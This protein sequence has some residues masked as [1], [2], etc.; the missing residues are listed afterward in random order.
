MEE[1]KRILELV[2][3]GILSTEEA[4]SLLENLAYQEDAQREEKDFGKKY[5]KVDADYESK[6]ES[7]DDHDKKE[8][9]DEDQKDSA[10]YLDELSQQINQYSAKIDTVNEE[11][12][13]LQNSLNNAQAKI[14]QSKEQ[15]NE[16]YRDKKDEIR[17][18]INNA[19]R[20]KELLSLVTE[21]DQS[22][23]ISQINEEI[24]NEQKVFEELNQKMSQELADECGDLLNQVEEFEKQL[25]QLKEEKE[26]YYHEMH[27]L[28][29]ESWSQ[30]AKNVSNQ[31]DIPEDW[32][33]GAEESFSKA[34][35]LVTHTAEN[36]GQLVNQLIDKGKDVLDH[37]EWKELDFNI[38]VPKIVEA[39]FNKSWTFEQTTATILDFKNAHGDLFFEESDDDSIHIDA[40]VKIYSSYDEETPEQALANRLDLEIN[41]DLFKFHLSNKRIHAAMIIRLPKRIYDY[42]SVTTLNGAIDFKNIHAQDIFIKSTN[43]A[44][45]FDQL[46]ATMLEIKGT[47]GDISIL[48]AHLRD[49]MAS[50]MNGDFR[51]IGDIQSSDISLTNGTVRL[52]FTGDELIRVKAS[53]VNGSVKIALPESVNLDGQA[54]STL[55]QVKSQ[56]TDVDWTD[57]NQRRQHQATFERYTKEGRVARIQ[58]QT[59][60]GNVMLKTTDR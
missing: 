39:E 27:G 12:H 5:D 50:T 56:L 24:A 14:N 38:S 29:M 10:A 4:L 15:I 60:T 41:D 35:D 11:I 52:T 55:G 31:L 26:T 19:E 30:K 21:L 25:S 3:K 23:E 44:I 8:I 48:D 34:S 43:G 28:K 37:F 17:Q 1:R 2:K 36:V 46:K 32:R 13:E 54:Q 6:N 20:Q 42:V 33:Q 7:L 40:Q 59:T 51:A 22:E 47:N 45:N 9:K 16:K 18:R 57:N 49:L 58:A 53:S